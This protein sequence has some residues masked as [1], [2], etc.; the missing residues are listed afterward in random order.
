MDA[1]ILIASR[2]KFARVCVEVDLGKLLKTGSWMRGRDWRLQ[3]E[4]LLD[5]CFL[6]GRY[7]H[8]EIVCPK[9]T[10]KKGT[11]EEGSVNNNNEKSEGASNSEGQHPASKS[12][13][14]EWMVAQWSHRR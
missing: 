7:G 3:Y 4:G 11:T 6:C 14:D 12:P 10:T 8:R 13:F 2:G 9:K 1:T 5:L